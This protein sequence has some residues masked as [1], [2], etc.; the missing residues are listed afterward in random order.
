MNKILLTGRLV[1]DA[2]MSFLPGTGMP[3]V[4]FTVA[5]DR[6]YQKDKN[7]KKVDFI[8]CEQIGKHVEKLAQYLTKG[9][10][11]GIEGELNIDQFEKDGQ[12]KSFTKVKVDRLE[13]LGGR[14]QE[15]HDPTGKFKEV[16][17]DDDLPF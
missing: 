15:E 3:K 1:K 13:F 14:K 4:T 12:K 2:E 10:M 6:A 7:N 5:T 8:P 16:L 11:I 9:K 17:D